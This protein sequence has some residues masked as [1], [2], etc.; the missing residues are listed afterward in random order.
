MRLT[1]FALVGLIL[2]AVCW[3]L[4]SSGK[5]T[6]PRQEPATINVDVNLVNVFL[7]V[8]SSKGDFISGLMRDDFRIF[9]DDVEQKISVFEKD[10]VD[11]S[12][13]ILIDNSGSMVDTL[14]V[15]KTG[16]IDFVGKRRRTDEFFVITFG[17][18]VQTIL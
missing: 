16:V 1:K 18:S 4:M 14:P 12:F 5:L 15:M 8:Q 11:S 3:P 10:S 7:T 6:A 17:T 13:G 2:V 9:E